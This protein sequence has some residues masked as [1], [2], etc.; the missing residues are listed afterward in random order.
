[1]T[2]T[3]VAPRTTAD[4]HST[5]QPFPEVS[6]LPPGSAASTPPQRTSAACAT[7]QT[8]VLS[9]STAG[10]GAATAS[11]SADGC[12]RWSLSRRW[13]SGPTAAWIMLNPSRADAATDDPTL[14]RVIGFAQAAGFGQITVANVYGW[15]SP[16]PSTLRRVPDPVGPDNDQAISAAAGGG[17]L[18]VAA[19][20][21]HAAP[22]RIAEVLELLSHRTVWCL[23]RTRSGQPRHP[24]YVPARTPLQ[25]YRHPRH[26]WTDWQQILDP[27]VDEL[28]HERFCPTCGLDE[29]GVDD[30]RMGEGW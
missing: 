5:R 16:S 18:V 30:H 26:D 8:P 29:I 20:G 14:R 19:W 10:T 1:M 4:G 24:L 7:G 11:L 22:D 6:C 15:R 13:A 21:T 28:L 2:S 17:D 3:M 12:Y 25:I 23:G 27:G 9:N